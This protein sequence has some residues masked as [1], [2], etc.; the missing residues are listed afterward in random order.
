MAFESK[1]LPVE[2]DAL[3]PDGSEIRLLSVATS[4][5][6]MVQCSLVPGKITRPVRHRSVE[7]MWHCVAGSGALWRSLEGR[8]DLLALTPGVSCSISAGTCFQFRSD[9]DAPLE[10]VIATMPPWPGSARR[11]HV[12]AAGNLRCRAAIA[13]RLTPTLWHTSSSTR[14]RAAA[15]PVRK[16]HS[17]PQRPRGEYE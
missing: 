10:I 12:R 15:W 11:S 7:E 6:S 14:R 9:G 8:E 1:H 16:V 4:G 17:Q 13:A 3:A 5:G 2:P